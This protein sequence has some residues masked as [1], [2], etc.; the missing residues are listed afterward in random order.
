MTKIQRAVKEYREGGLTQLL[1]FTRDHYSIA[2]EPRL[3]KESIWS[4]DWDVL[5]VLD[6]CR[7][8]TFESVFEGNTDQIR[9][10]ASCS[11]NWVKRTFHD[12]D[13]SNVAYITGNPFVK[14]I[15]LD[16]FA[17]GHFQNVEPVC[18]VETVS[19]KK[20]T[21]RAINVWRRRDELGVEKLVIHY[22]Q[23]HAPFRSRPEWFNQWNGTEK[24]GSSVWDQLRGDLNYEAFFEAYED[25][26]KWVL[27]DGVEPLSANCNAQIA[28]TA[29]HGNAAGEWTYYGH[30]KGA[31]AP[32]V[33]VVP[34][35][36]INGVDEQTRTPEVEAKAE[37]TDVDKQLRALGYK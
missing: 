12:T 3:P 25:N 17:Y 27:E 32:S 35:A 24:F 28:I 34:W 5:C 11:E 19:P 13:V 31:L 1:R 36:T 10:V 9:S 20:L 21:D 33:R 6:G 37:P 4:K 18:G 22:M 2:I 16:R 26:L 30:P 8:D 15:D 29:D 23:P 7:A 14:Y